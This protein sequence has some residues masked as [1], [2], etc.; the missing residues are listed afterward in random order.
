MASA[1]FADQ[2][3]GTLRG[4]V[5]RHPQMQSGVQL[6]YAKGAGGLQRRTANARDDS[7]AE[8]YPKRD[9]LYRDYWRRADIASGHRRA[10]RGG[11]LRMQIPLAALNHQRH[12]A[13][14]QAA[15]S[16][17]RDRIGGKP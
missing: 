17:S 9:G 7:V 11:A 8:A 4:Y 13:G 1:H 12:A 3:R 6:L 15:D 14:P 5:L 16:A 10:R 2:G